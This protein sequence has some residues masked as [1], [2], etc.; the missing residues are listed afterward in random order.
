[1]K[2]NFKKE[3]IDNIVIKP[4]STASHVSESTDRRKNEDRD[5]DYSLRVPS[6]RP[7]FGQPPE[8]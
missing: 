7:Y 8:W 4:I 1:M 6:N 3:I 2:R 5:P